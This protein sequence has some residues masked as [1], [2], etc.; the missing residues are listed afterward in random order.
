LRFSG[1]EFFLL[2]LLPF[3]LFFLLLSLSL[4]GCQRMGSAL[5][6]VT[7]RR[8]MRKAK[9]GPASAPLTAYPEE[10]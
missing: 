7:D 1:I 4:Y 6:L 10:R 5:E 8:P 2:S 9:R 3:L